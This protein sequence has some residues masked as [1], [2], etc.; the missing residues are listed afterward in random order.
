MLLS[1]NETQYVAYI[2]YDMISNDV[3]L[4]KPQPLSEQLFNKLHWSIQKLF[5]IAIKKIDTYKY[6]LDINKGIFQKKKVIYHT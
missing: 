2:I 6:N 5:K 4:L 1:S 3:N